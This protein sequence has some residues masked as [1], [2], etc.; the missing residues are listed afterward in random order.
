MNLNIF[1]FISLV[2]ILPNFS[3][4]VEPKEKAVKPEMQ[5][6]QDEK[7]DAKIRDFMKNSWHQQQWIIEHVR[8]N[9]HPG[10]DI[11][12]RVKGT[13]WMVRIEGRELK[14]KLD[15]DKL[16]P[17][18]VYAFTGVPVDQHYGV[19]TFYLHSGPVKVETKK[20]EEKKT[21]SEPQDN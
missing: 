11:N 7:A 14:E 4:A 6:Y 16:D 17:K 19:I 18:S 2:C 5:V 8:E 10:T 21:S 9:T 12:W 20:A 15:L 1:Y 3:H 13:M